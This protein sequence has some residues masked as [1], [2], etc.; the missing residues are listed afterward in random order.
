MKLRF[1][2]NNLLVTAALF[3][4]TPCAG[5]GPTLDA[6]KATIKPGIL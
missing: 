2:T 6:R 3:L 5:G 4:F 1:I